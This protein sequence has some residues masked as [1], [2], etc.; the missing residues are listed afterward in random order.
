MIRCIVL[1]CSSIVTL[2]AARQDELQLRMA[3]AFRLQKA[4]Q[5]VEAERVTRAALD[6]ARD[7]P[8]GSHQNEIVLLLRLSGIL[9][10]QGRFT[11]AEQSSRAALAFAER[12]PDNM[13]LIP[14]ALCTLGDS[15]VW[16][17]KPAEAKPFLERA[18]NLLSG[19]G[20]LEGYG[21]DLAL[22]LLSTMYRAMGNPERARP[23]ARRALFL[24]QKLPKTDPHVV[25]S[26]ADE[27]GYVL[28]LLKQYSAAA[29]EFRRV[30]AIFGDDCALDKMCALA[31]IGLGPILVKQG[32]LAEGA[33]QLEAGIATVESVLGPAAMNLGP[34]LGDL[35]KTYY[36]Q[37][38]Y[39]D[40]ARAI[41]RGMAIL[42]AGSGGLK[43]EYP[44]LLMV[45]ADI[46]RARGNKSEAKKT[47]AR[48][49]AM[50]RETLLHR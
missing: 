15:L 39:D 24:V 13:P 25:A 21:E 37:G 7:S 5:L 8:E 31:R 42:E 49:K 30:I 32:K 48:A 47:L 22:S 1:I 40:A 41:R 6:L 36:L 23:L 50:W 28:L 29:V 27:L 18:L 34:A 45:L 43:D 46:E 10:D 16:A 9:Q 38:R 44:K 19:S 3:E 14:S 26:A 17:G 20:G 11:E 12:R 2:Q 33:E 35:S 4:G